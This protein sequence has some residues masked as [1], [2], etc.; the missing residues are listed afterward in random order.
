MKLLH[1]IWPT[2]F[3]IRKGDLRS[4]ITQFLI[5]LVVCVLAG[6]LLLGVLG[7]LRFLRFVFRAAGLLVELYGG[8]GIILCILKFLNL[9]K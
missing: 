2:P 5:L 4:F 6:W 1:T 7:R 9:V 3:L 8:I